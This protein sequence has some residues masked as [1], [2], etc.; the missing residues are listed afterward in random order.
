ME[1]RGLRA[2]KKKVDNGRIDQL[3]WVKPQRHV[4]NL[5]NLVPLVAFRF[6]S[7]LKMGNELDCSWMI[8]MQLISASYDAVEMAVGGF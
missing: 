5:A 4:G 1:G 2:L 3:S 8:V 7:M 6:R